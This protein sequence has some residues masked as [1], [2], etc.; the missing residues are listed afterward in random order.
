MQPVIIKYGPDRVSPAWDS[1]GAL[2]HVFL[3]LANPFHSVTARQV[4]SHHSEV[5]VTGGCI[6]CSFLHILIHSRAPA[7]SCP[8]RPK[9][10]PGPWAAGT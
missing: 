9:G 10:Q 1:V 6:P 7:K 8:R 5:S 4:N 3:M 2:W